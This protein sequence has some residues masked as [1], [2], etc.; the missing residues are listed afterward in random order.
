[1][2]NHEL[3]TIDE[4]GREKAEEGRAGSYFLG[5]EARKDLEIYMGREL[6]VPSAWHLVAGRVQVQERGLRVVLYQGMQQ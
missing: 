5:K 1:M 3:A 4:V 6:D 2:R